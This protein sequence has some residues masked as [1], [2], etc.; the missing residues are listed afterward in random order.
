MKVLK[1]I[2]KIFAIVVGCIILL[3]IV[4][5]LIFTIPRVQQYAAEF[6]LSK[7]KPILKTEISIEKIRLRGLAAVTIKGLYFEDQRKDTLFY[8]NKVSAKVN[9]IDLLQNNLTIQSASISNF[10]GNVYRQTPEAPFNFQFIIDAFAPDPNKKKE[11]SEKPIMISINN[12]RL[13]NGNLRYNILSESETPGKFNVSHFDVENFSLSADITSLDMKNLVAD[14]GSL[15]FHEK[16]AGIYVDNLQAMVRSKGNKLWSDK[17]DLKF[18]NSEINI[19]KAAY[20][21]E[22]KEFELNVKKSKIEPKDISIFTNQFSHLDKTFELEADI[23]GQLPSVNVKNLIAKYGN[24]T[25]LQIKG[26]IDDYSKYQES[27]I[28]ININNFKTNINDLQSFIRVGAPDIEL[29]EQVLALENVSMNLSAKGKLNKFKTNILFGTTPGSI[30]FNG[31]G[32]IQNDF[33][34]ISIEGAVS[35]SNLKVAKIIGDKVGVDDVTLNTSAYLTIRP[36]IISVKTKGKI[37]SVTYNNFKYSNIYI[38]GLYSGKEISGTVSTDTEQNKFNLTADLSLGKPMS[39]IVNGSIDKLFMTPVF[40]LKDWQNPYL[41]AQIYANLQ[42]EDIDNIQGAVV[43]DGVSIYDDNF[44]YNPG[45]IS[46]EA[47]QDEETGVKKIQLSS[48]VL[49]AKIEGDYY[50]TTIGSQITNMLSHHLPTLIKPSESE[51][52]NKKNVFAF[53]LMLKNTEDISYALSLPF[54][55][56]EPGTLKGKLDMDNVSSLVINGYIPRLKIGENDIRETKFDLTSGEFNGVKFNA[57]TYLVQDNGHVNARLNMLAAN[58]SVTNGIIFDL[59]SGETKANGDMGISAS[60]S[61]D[62]EDN[63]IT[64]VNIESSNFMFDQEMIR[65]PKSKV[66]VRKDRVSINNFSLEQNG[67]LLL[68]IDG[69]VSKSPEDSVILHFNDTELGNILAAI[70]APQFKGSLNGAITIAQALQDPQIQTKDLKIENLRTATD[71][72]GT[73]SLNGNWDRAREGLALDIS[74]IKNNVN[75]LGIAGFIP[76]AKTNSMDVDL[77][78]NKLPLA[79]VQPFAVDV[80]SKLSGSLNSKINLSGNLSE[81]ITD[82]WLG[83]DEGVMTVA[84][85]NATYTVSDTINIKPGSVGMDDLVIKD[86]NNHEAHLKV[87]MTH[88]NFKG[89]EY[90]ASLKFKDFL[91][92][93]NDSRTD[94][95]AYGNLKLSGDINIVGSSRGIFG[96]ANLRNESR[97]NVM[98]EIPQTANAS[99]NN[100]VIYVNKNRPEE[101]SLA[102]LRRDKDKVNT[103]NTKINRSMPIRIQAV[104]QIN[105]MLEAGVLINPVSGDMLQIKGEG[106]LRAI[107]DSQ[108]NPTVRLYGD[109]VAASGKFKYNFLN[110]KSINFKIQEGST[111]T[112]VGDPM[113]TQFNISAY[114]EVNANLATLSE[115]FTIQMSDTRMPVHATLD[116]QGN[117]E[118]MNLQYGIDLPDAT[119]EIKQR[120]SSLVSTDEQK[121][122]QFANLIAT[123]NFYPAEGTLGGNFNESAF[124]NY[125]T[126]ALTRGLDALLA[127]VLSDDWSISTNFE[128]VDGNFDTMRMGVGISKSFLDNKLRISSNISYGDNS[129]MTSQQ[130]FMGEFE[131]EYDINNWLMIRAYNRANKQYYNRAPT[132][133]GV[134]LVINRDARKFKDLFKFSY[135]RRENDD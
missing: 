101:D 37:E 85:T 100:G 30:R 64:N 36:N 117:L 126:S 35:T 70:N 72:L 88:R 60:F 62:E 46:L 91:L 26:F 133:Q 77:Q 45:T 123:G 4:I 71:T 17:V 121:I 113:N 69:V 44:I 50:L 40:T 3:N 109:Y 20:D 129:V 94:Q 74:L 6:A 27:D 28:D 79:W 53:D 83:I 96:N 84:F 18:N 29:P 95:V 39:F 73:L 132:T 55:N 41:M 38:D 12:I 10:V 82:G 110:F 86:N 118:R 65:M 120:F 54:I 61:R 81:P 13:T 134:G 135:K 108:A 49:D 102:F 32:R 42:G 107:F 58:D 15:N 7:L 48:S 87:A 111:V 9:V 43:F 80:F 51:P 97:S 66:V 124:T 52:E 67:M 63:L 47:G 99:K 130:A 116:I 92:L 31:S 11:P 8:A 114:N 14:V 112:M 2:A 122:T 24:Q 25:S 127:S 119:D 93:N 68:G 103:L 78:I 75:Y 56:V 105:D 115:S 131:L 22:S 76:T 34:N 5:V 16:N 57:N 98:I 23:E 19:P 21:T 59:I 90:Q 33:K 106:E 128:T 89:V 1:K 104:L 125:A